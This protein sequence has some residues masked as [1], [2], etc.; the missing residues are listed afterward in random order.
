MKKLA[1]ATIVLAVAL[2]VPLSGMAQVSVSVDTT[3]PTLT[4]TSPA[5]GSTVSVPDVVVTGTAE[6][7]S[8]LVV[9]GYAVAVSGTGTF[10]VELPLSPG[11]NTI[12]ATVT[13]AAGTSAT[14]TMTVTYDN[15]V[16]GAQNSITSLMTRSDLLLGLVAVALAL[17]ATSLVLRWKR[18]SGPK[19]PPKEVSSPTTSDAPPK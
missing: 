4:F 10:S 17:G 6:V 7:G 19:G 2:V 14:R 3:T 1:I 13:N 16:P 15:P 18:S 9:N 5:S 8:T 12:T 11:S